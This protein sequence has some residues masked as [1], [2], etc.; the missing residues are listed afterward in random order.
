MGGLLQG[1]SRAAPGKLGLHARAE[2]ERVMAL[3][4]REGGPLPSPGNVGPEIEPAV[5]HFKTKRGNSLEM[6]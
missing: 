4:S 1:A 3:E 2:G 6:L 5:S